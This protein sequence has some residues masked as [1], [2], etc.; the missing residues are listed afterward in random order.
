M[1]DLIP[2]KETKN[3]YQPT[4]HPLNAAE[5]LDR[6]DIRLCTPPEPPLYPPMA[7]KDS[8]QYTRI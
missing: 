6:L 2:I 1:A 8:E 4:N 5:V 3:E 7:V